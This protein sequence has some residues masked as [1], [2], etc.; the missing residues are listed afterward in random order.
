MRKRF[1]SCK[2]FFKKH[3]YYS[4]KYPKNCY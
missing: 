2:Y 1:N 4:G 3:D